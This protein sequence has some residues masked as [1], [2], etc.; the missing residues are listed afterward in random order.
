MR[1]GRPTNYTVH[2]TLTYFAFQLKVYTFTLVVV[3]VRDKLSQ[4]DRV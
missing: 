3:R 2:T 4:V 1:C